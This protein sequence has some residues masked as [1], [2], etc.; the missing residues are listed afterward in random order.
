MAPQHGR[1][2]GGGLQAPPLF[3]LRRH[4]RPFWALLRGQARPLGTAWRTRA[5]GPALP[6][7]TTRP[8]APEAGR[9]SQNTSRQAPRACTSME[10]LV[11]MCMCGAAALGP[12]E[13]AGRSAAAVDAASFRS[14]PY[15][16]GVQ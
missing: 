14:P 13:T 4:S 15:G 11:R 5:P 8:C 9:R 7:I 2:A 16:R 6:A 10:M 12:A 3:P 1:R